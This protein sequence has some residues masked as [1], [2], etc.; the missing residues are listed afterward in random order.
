MKTSPLK[1][2]LLG[3][4]LG[5][6]LLSPL[7]HARYQTGFEVITFKPAIDAGDYFSVYGSQNL[8]AWQGNMGFY[9]DYSNRPLQFVASG[10]A[11]GR[12]SVI[13]NLFVANL[14][15]ALGFTDWFEVGV[16]LP[17]VLYNQFF[18]DDAAANEDAGGGLG[19]IQFTM[20]FRLVD[21]EKNK[22]GLA[23]APF[24]TLPSGDTSRYTGNGS[25]TGGVLLIADYLIHP[26]VSLALNAGVTFR[27]DVTKHGVRVDDQLNY[28]LGVN[29]KFTE[30][31]HGIVEVTGRSTMAD[32]NEANSPLEAGAGIR[33]FIKNTGFSV[34]LGATAGILDGV[35]APRVRGYAGL[36][37]TSPTGNK[38]INEDGLYQFMNTI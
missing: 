37:W 4:L 30:D 3:A 24:F 13:D 16:N 2:G 22:I 8:K 23:F 35:G 32:M 7:S 38:N 6:T 19:D 21:S 36:R 26:R 18:T 34:D 17:V 14:Y 1:K 20:K 29:V 25:V 27:D 31:F 10:L 11:I 5:L 12:Q 28:G 9:L 15:G 33:Y